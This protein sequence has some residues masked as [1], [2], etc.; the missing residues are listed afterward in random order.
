MQSVSDIL[1]FCAKYSLCLKASGKLKLTVLLRRGD[2]N[3][4]THK[5]GRAT[6]QVA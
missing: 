4:V 1:Y 5:T 3:S 2:C 6:P